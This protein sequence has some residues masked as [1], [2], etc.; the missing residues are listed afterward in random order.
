MNPQRKI[1][2]IGYGNPGRHDDGL[3]P[4]LAAAAE[5]LAMPGLTVES[6]YQLCVEHAELAAR[7]DVVIFAD[8]SLSGPEPFS[9]DPLELA[10][11]AEGDAS[12]GSRKQDASRRPVG[13]TSFSSH[14]LGPGEVLALAAGLFGTCPTAYLL[15]IRGYCFDQFG[16]G[17][18]P[19]ARF[20]LACA[21][22]FLENSLRND[23]WSPRNLPRP[24]A[25]TAFVCE[26]LPCRKV[27]P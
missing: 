23:S 12:P 27:S 18:S 13:T 6:D 25:S 19:Q 24:A 1:L 9:F 21:L 7:H 14:A 5:K 8:A 17:L 4:A 26:E 3:G 11:P 20:N 10:R 22:D 15:G 16:E 2:L